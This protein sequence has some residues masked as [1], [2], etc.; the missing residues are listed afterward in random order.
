MSDER[1]RIVLKK[2]VLKDI[3]K[4]PA[5]ILRRIQEEI[6]SLAENPFPNGVESIQGYARHYRI[7]IGNYRVVY[8]VATQVRIITIIRIGHRQKVYREL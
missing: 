7:R 5:V 1:Y 2:S 3:R 6:V 8:E 4:I